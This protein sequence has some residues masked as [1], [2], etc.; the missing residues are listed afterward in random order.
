MLPLGRGWL[1]G[2][3]ISGAVATAVDCSS[4]AVVTG[5]PEVTRLNAGQCTAVATGTPI[6][7]R[8]VRVEGQAG[9]VSAASGHGVV[10]FSLVATAHAVA[11][12]MAASRVDANADAEVVAGA[13]VAP[14]AV[15]TV[16][17]AFR[18]SAFAAAEGDPQVYVLVKSSPAT[19]AAWCEGTTGY[20]AGGN[21]AS[22]A[23]V[24]ADAQLITPV[25]GTAVAHGDVAPRAR[26]AA[27]SAVICVGDFG[28]VFDPYIL[29]GTVKYFDANVS[30]TATATLEADPYV[31]SVSLSVGRCTVLGYPNARKGVRGKALAHSSGTGY[32]QNVIPAVG[33]VIVGASAFAAGT[34]KFG[35]RG[36]INSGAGAWPVGNARRTRRGGGASSGIASLTGG[37]A[38]IDIYALPSIEAYAL[39]AGSGQRGR[40]TSGATAAT[41]DAQAYNQVNDVSYAPRWRT[42]E[43]GKYP[44][45]I[46][47]GAEPRVISG[48]GG[49]RTVI[50]AKSA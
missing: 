40:P 18:A 29:R 50:Q 49:S 21:T 4:T 3:L 31:Y 6:A 7:V 32:G 35:A 30:P 44:T 5:Q 12:A 19:C 26:V 25:W 17:A 14:R 15:R 20:F 42:T 46:V 10:D 23:T 22:A 33:G 45:L 8:G 24:T 11:V 9:C 41:A 34:A 43:V 39:G 1:G 28:S 38:R 16:R 48:Y 13:S 2:P 37:W 27:N 36:R 47:I